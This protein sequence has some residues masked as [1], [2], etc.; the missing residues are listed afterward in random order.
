VI[1][2]ERN[3]YKTIKS[4]ATLSFNATTKKVTTAFAHSPVYISALRRHNKRLAFFQSLFAR[5]YFSTNSNTKS[6]LSEILIKYHQ[7]KKRDKS[8]KLRKT[9]HFY[10]PFIKFL[11]VQGNN[12][13]AVATT[14]GW[15]LHQHNMLAYLTSSKTLI[16][17]F[18]SPAFASAP[19]TNLL[20][21]FFL[22]KERT[23]TKLKYSRV[24]QYDTSS[25][26]SAALLAGLLGF[27]ISEKFGF[28][29][30]DAADL[31]VAG[32]YVLL[33]CFTVRVFFKT[34]ELSTSSI[35]VY[36]PR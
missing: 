32:M 18:Q 22:R 2:Q 16:N 28:E 9:T 5:P 31:Y 23:Y 26:A 36:N 27:L 14:K 21:I 12:V 33:T 20:T 17:K 3:F 4:R 10:G 19:S 15:T 30:V 35:P 24:P 8:L 29:M 13:N 7:F 11:Y 1:L 25:N 6:D 34:I